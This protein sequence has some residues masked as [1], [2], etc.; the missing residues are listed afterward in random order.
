MYN[1]GESRLEYIYD[2]LG[3]TPGYYCEEANRALDS[4]R[5]VSSMTASC[6]EIRRLRQEKSIAKSKTVD[7]TDSE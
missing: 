3:Y 6:E 5:I 2:I 1:D 4:K 7:C